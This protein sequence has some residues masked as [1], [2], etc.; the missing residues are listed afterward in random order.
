MGESLNYYGTEA[1]LWGHT[2]LPFTWGPIDRGRTPCSSDRGPG[3]IARLH[4][5]ALL[6][7]AK[8]NNG[9][10]VRAFFLFQQRL[11]E[12]DRA[13]SSLIKYAERYYTSL[14]HQII[15]GLNTVYNNEI[16]ILIF[17]MHSKRA[18]RAQSSEQRQHYNKSQLVF[19]PP[20][21]SWA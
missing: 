18:L 14:L 2:H 16:W 5:P 20:C 1:P 11:I 10:L 7:A 17:S 3:P 13:K 8:C 9:R 4:P 21:R 19:S 6:H 15:I 12:S